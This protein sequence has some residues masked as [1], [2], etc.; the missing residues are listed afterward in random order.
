MRVLITGG[1]GNLGGALAHEAVN[2]GHTEYVRPRAFVFT[3]KTSSIVL[4]P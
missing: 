2:A 3:T 1:T 4:V